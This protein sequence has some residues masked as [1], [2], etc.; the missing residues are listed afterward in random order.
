MEAEFDRKAIRYTFLKGSMTCVASVIEI[1]FLPFWLLGLGQWYSREAFE[2][3][4]M[5]RGD[6]HSRI[7]IPTRRPIGTRSKTTFPAFSRGPT[8]PKPKHP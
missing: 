5:T 6:A 4:M 7:S 8:G 3:W 1:L 2:R